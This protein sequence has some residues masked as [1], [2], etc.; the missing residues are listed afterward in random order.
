[1]ASLEL[2]NPF[3]DPGSGRTIIPVINKN[4]TDGHS[5]GAEALLTFAP[6]RSWRLAGSYS[7]V[8]MHLQSS[9]LDLNRGTF[10][11]DTTPRHQF[12]LR[13]FLDL[14][15]GFQFDAMFR[16]LGAVRRDPQ[17]VSGGGIP[18]YSELDVRVAW[19][20]W[21][22]LEVSVVGQNLLHDHHL[23][24]GAPAARGE[25]ERSVYGKIAWGF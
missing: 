14:P 20:G 11:E 4:L 25:I 24:F 23:E 12:G 21:K 2:G 15:N 8:S 13:S 19:R 7:Y 9:G 3:V 17:I 10:L 6:F 5:Q 16:R 18:A 1:L 22:Q